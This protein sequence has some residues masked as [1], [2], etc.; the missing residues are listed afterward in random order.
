VIRRTAFRGACRI[1]C[2]SLRATLTSRER[3]IVD[4]VA[5]GLTAA[6]MGRALGISPRTVSKHLQHAY[7]KIGCHDRL[8][9]ARSASGR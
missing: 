2:G 6:A 4:L 7:R 3:E 5:E 8:L 9:V 1:S